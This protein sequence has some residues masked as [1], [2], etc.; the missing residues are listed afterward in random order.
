MLIHAYHI[1]T[2]LCIQ[3]FQQHKLLC[4]VQQSAHQS[5]LDASGSR[6][7]L[8]EISYQ[9]LVMIPS[10]CVHKDNDWNIFNIHYNWGIVFLQMSHQI[11]HNKIQRLGHNLPLIWCKTSFCFCILAPC[12]C[13]TTATSTMNTTLWKDSSAKD[14]YGKKEFLIKLN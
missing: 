8:S 10:A 1:N 9:L 2:I 11:N 3:S 7:C 5:S 6:V 4:A 13:K 14:N 12:N